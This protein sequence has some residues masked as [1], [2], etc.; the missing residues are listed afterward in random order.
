MEWLRSYRPDLVDRY[1]GLYARGAYAPREEQERLRRML[2][3]TQART[4]R[5]PPRRSPA[6]SRGVRRSRDDMRA[7]QRAASPGT[8]LR[9]A[10]LAGE[11][12]P[13]MAPERAAGTDGAGDSKRSERSDSPRVRVGRQEALF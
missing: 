8:S 1:E 12:W 5:E 9:R 6:D 13:P 3:T 7:E 10:R 4:G 11:A 2:A